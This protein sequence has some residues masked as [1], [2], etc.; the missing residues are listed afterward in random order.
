MGY[1]CDPTVDGKFGGGVAVRGENGF[2]LFSGL[3]NCPRLTGTVE[4]W[5]RSDAEEPVWSDGVGRWLLVLYPERGEYGAR[6]GMQPNI[7]SLYKTPANQLEFKLYEGGIPRYA[8]GSRL[9]RGDTGKSLSL[10]VGNLDAG[11]WHHIVC[12][13][14]LRPPGRLWLLVDG[15]GT[16]AQLDRAENALEPNPGGFILLGGL[17]GLP[18]DK[19]GPSACVLDDFRIQS[20]TVAQRLS[21]PPPPKPTTCEVDQSRLLEAEDAVR[22][23]LDFLLRLQFRGGLLPAYSWPALSPAGWGDIGRGVDM[24]YPGSARLGETLIRAWRIWGDDRYLDGAIEAANMFCETQ[25]PEGAWAY[26]YTYSRGQL[27][28]NH[29]R[30]YIAQTMQSNQIRF[31]CLMWRLLGDT[32]YEQAIRKAGDWHE[33]IQFPNGAWGWEAY[34]LDH[35]GP[36][37]HPAL[38]DAVTPQAMSDLFVIW[39]ATGDD[40]YLGPLKRAGQWLIDAQSGPPMYGWADQYDANNNFI[41][42]RSFEPPAVSMQAV[43]SATRGLLLMYD[44]TG[45][46][47]YIEPLRKVLAWM[48]S[49][50]EDQHGWLWYAHRDYS[51]EENTAL[52]RMPGHADPVKQGVPIRAG[53]PVVAYYNELLPV[54]HE[55]AVREVIPR[56]AAHYGVKYGW[57]EEPI[58][59]ALEERVQG[60]VFPGRFGS[61]PRSRFAETA[62]TRADFA[63][64]FAKSPRGTIVAKLA[65]FAQ[66]E[67]G[68]LVTQHRDYGRCF[69]PNQ[70][71]SYCGQVLDDI[72]AARVALGDYPPEWIPRYA[73]WT[74]GCWAYMDP[75]R[76]YFATPLTGPGRI[77]PR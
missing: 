19:V 5:A 3:D 35:K 21:D 28:P 14:D 29:R 64:A 10:P 12:S 76:D 44:V 33:S 51:A 77:A 69:N 13:W 54:T 9:A 70:A 36:Y 66:G 2:L 6:Y 68:D 20:D 40:K 50:P 37:G 67:P 75:Q 26:A 60:P 22:Q 31:L 74:G 55:K 61:L 23:M 52:V 32:R 63:A 30:A 16:T 15:V 47:R 34:P 1:N 72:E 4:F 11:S 59:K 24:W 8:L 73:R 62:P 49:V 65:A 18:G 41:W 17:S 38:N 7:L 25:F 42:M 43:S 45:D 27:L 48:E 56:L 57:T 58:R 71:L 39:C 53:E 46:P